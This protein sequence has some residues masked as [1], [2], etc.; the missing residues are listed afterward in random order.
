MEI[1]RIRLID[2]DP[3]KHTL[4]DS[5]FTNRGINISAPV[6]SDDIVNGRAASMNFEMMLEFAKNNPNRK[7]HFNIDSGRGGGYES[8][9]LLNKNIRIDVMLK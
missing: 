7:S 1:K 2:F 6:R 9:W 8:R 4:Y 5:Y 3:K